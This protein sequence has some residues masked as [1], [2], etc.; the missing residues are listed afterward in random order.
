MRSDATHAGQPFSRELQVVRV[1]V[2]GLHES[3]CLLLASARVVY[4][5][6]TAFFVHKLVEIAPCPTQ[7]LAEII[8]RNLHHLR[9][10]FAGNTEHLP[11]DEGKA[12]AAVQAQ[13]HARHAADASFLHE[14]R[15][16]DRHGLRIRQ[17]E[18]G[19]IVKRATHIGEGRSNLLRL[20][21]AHIEQV[22]NRDTV[23]PGAELTLAQKSAEL[24]YYPDENLLCSVL[25]NLTMPKHPDCDVENPRLMAPHQSVERISISGL[26]PG[27]EF[28][29][30]GFISLRRYPIEWIDGI[31]SGFTSGKL[32]VHIC[33]S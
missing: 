24:G 1:H 31:A 33:H 25:S 23:K 17:I 13:E 21:F 32:G 14:H 9:T 26:R 8:R 29:V 20:G 3:A 19:G 28:F 5:Y 30:R 27:N 4:V 10:E 11:E 15:Q 6:Q 7:Q 22:I 2:P 16:V 18:V 12:L